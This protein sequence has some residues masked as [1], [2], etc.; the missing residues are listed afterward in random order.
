MV[1]AAAVP[2]VEEEAEARGFLIEA[3]ASYG[4]ID[5]AHVLPGAPSE[6]LLLRF[7]RAQYS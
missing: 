1:T 4:G 3:L 5:E 2:W 7:T 6:I